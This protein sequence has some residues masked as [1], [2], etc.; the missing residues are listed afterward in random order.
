MII[1]ESEPW[2][3]WPDKVS[4]GIN[5]GEIGK[6]FEGYTD[7]TLAMNIKVLTKSE[8]K[9]T[10]FAKLPNYCG[11]DLESNN[12]LLLILKLLKNNEE[13]YQYIISD[14]SLNDCY[15]ILIFRYLKDKN[16]VDVSIN[17]NIVIQY[18]LDNDEQLTIG[19]EPH[20]IF[21]SGNFPHNNFNLNYCSYDINFLLISKSYKLYNEILNIKNNIMLDDSIIGLYDFNKHT[22]FKVYD[23]S[24]NCNF[25]HKIIE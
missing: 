12:K 19:N 20:I 8:T 24:E 17:D 3:L 16:I 5:K 9:R 15:N 25:L 23:L 4:Y 1:N 18:K 11:I 6:T 22:D 21:G 10:L 7:F 14:D 2:L 13:T